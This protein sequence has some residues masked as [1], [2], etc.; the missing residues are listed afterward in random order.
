MTNTSH[1]A[2]PQFRLRSTHA[3]LRGLAVIVVCVAVIGGFI[4]QV[5]SRSAPEHLRTTAEPT[6]IHLGA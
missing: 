4:A 3:V 2:A 6:A 5:Q 1:A